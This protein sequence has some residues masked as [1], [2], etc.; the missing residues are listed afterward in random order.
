M[1]EKTPT[2][3]SQNDMHEHLQSVYRRDSRSIIPLL[4]S[5]SALRNVASDAAVWI[6]YMPHRPSC[7]SL[8]DFKDEAAPACSCG[9][10]ELLARCRE[11][12]K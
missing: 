11:A 4:D 12:G 7:A 1:S 8:M 9:R 3:L 5:D 2:V 10:Q 6:E